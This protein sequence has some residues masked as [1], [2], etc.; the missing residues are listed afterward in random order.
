MTEKILIIG[1]LGQVGRELIDALTIKYGKNQVVCS[2]IRKDEFISN[3]QIILDVMDFDALKNIVIEHKITQIYN[4]AALLSAT[5]EKKPKLGWKLTI[6][7]LLNTLD[8]AKEGLINKVF[9][10]SSIAVFGKTTPRNNTPQHTIIEPSTVYGIGKQAGEQWCSYYHANYGVD[11]RS[12]RY[13]GLIGY[14]SMPGGGTTDYAVDIFYA[15][16]KSNK[17]SCFLSENATLPM[18]YMGDAIKA[19]LSIMDAPAENIKVRTSYNIAGF[20]FSPAQLANEIKKFLPEFT[21]SYKPDFRDQI[22]ASW[23]KSIDDNAART[24]W[25]WQPDFSLTN[26]VE[27]MLTEIK[28]KL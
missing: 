5:A 3:T 12:I 1:G 28:K 19:T 22:A 11:V 18:M 13:P 16:L 17:Y 8:L 27:L 26:L 14:K 24:D 6:D 2:D 25:G 4:L 10:P 15:A 23:P 21:I 9:W 20:S 7:G